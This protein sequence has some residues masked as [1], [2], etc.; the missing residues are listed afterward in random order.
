MRAL[1]TVLALFPS[2]VMADCRDEQAFVY[3]TIAGNGWVVEAPGAMSQSDG[4]CRVTDVVLT[5]E[6]LVF[7]LGSVSW[8][9]E[10]LN[11]LKAGAGRVSIDAGIDDF[12]FAPRVQDPWLNYML[13][14]QNRRNLI[15]ATLRAGLDFEAG[16]LTV[17]GLKIDLPGENEIALDVAVR[18]VGPTLLT[19]L[20]SDLAAL[21]LERMSVAVENH[22][23]ADALILGFLVGRFSGVPGSPETVVEATKAELASIVRGLP[24]DVLPEDSKAALVALIDN[25]PAPWGRLSIDIE[26]AG[27]LPMSGFLALATS[28]DPLSP[29]ALRDAFSGAQIAIGFSPETGVE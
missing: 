1:L 29:D 9:L 25:G 28:T 11:A 19:G 7:G 2:A 16:R 3:E 15:D 21:E 4:L 27:G 18:G 13:A 14:E 17:D 5:Q 12:R 22:G 23:F 20:V 24:G 8:R 10:G 6:S 26:A